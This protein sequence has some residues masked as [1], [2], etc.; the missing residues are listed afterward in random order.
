MKRLVCLLLVILLLC[1]A[2]ALA[3]K[4]EID[5]E[6]ATVEQIQAAID[7]L[8]ALAAEKQ[9]AEATPAETPAPTEAPAYQELKK[10][11]KGETVKALQMRLFELKYLNVKGDGNFGDK[12]VQALKEFQKAVAFEPTG[13]AT[14]EIQQKLFAADAPVAIIYGKLDYKALER[15]PAKHTG[16]KIRFT[17][18]VIQVVEEAGADKMVSVALRIATKGN[19]DN[20]AYVTYVRKADDSR[21][22]EKDKVT[23][24]GAYG[25][26]YA[27]QSVGAGTVAIPQ[28][29]ADSVTRN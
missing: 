23:V 6:T 18:R 28:F 21:I 27:Y 10:G 25:G 14:V 8:T 9:K 19:Y 15:D 2:P 17:G 1:P 22:L 12:T 4:I 16:E 24:A 20:V 3:Q 26:I 11:S 5:P 13:I 29:T 7:Q